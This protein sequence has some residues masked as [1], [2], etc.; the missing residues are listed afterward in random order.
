M[1]T[2]VFELVKESL[3][4]ISSDENREALEG[5]DEKTIIYGQAGCFDSLGI[6]NLLA[7]LEDRIS[8]EFEIDVTL[9]DERA[10]SQKTSPFHSVATLTRYIDKLLKEHA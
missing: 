3:L 6:V 1:N 2:K 10:M 5:A 4:E 9:A 7:E 8:D